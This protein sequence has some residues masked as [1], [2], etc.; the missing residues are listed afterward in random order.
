[1][2][3]RN[4]SL[5]QWLWQCKSRIQID[6]AKLKDSKHERHSE[7]APRKIW[8]I[9]KQK[10][11][12]KFWSELGKTLRNY[13]SRN[14]E[15]LYMGDIQRA[16]SWKTLSTRYIQREIRGSSGRSVVKEQWSK[17]QFRDSDLYDIQIPRALKYCRWW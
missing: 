6:N 14:S 12:K 7:R 1:M 17:S 13:D 3:Y 11:N 8:K 16:P 9:R 2:C 5:T 15:R 4:T 10:Q